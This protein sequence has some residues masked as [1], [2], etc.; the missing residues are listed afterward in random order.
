MSIVHAE[1]KMQKTVPNSYT[2]NAPKTEDN[3]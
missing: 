2:Y 3:V 1:Q